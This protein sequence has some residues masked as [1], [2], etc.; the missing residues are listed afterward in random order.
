MRGGNKNKRI[1]RP[2]KRTLEESVQDGIPTLEEEKKTIGVDAKR[3]RQYNEDKVPSVNMHPSIACIE[4]K[5]ARLMDKA[6]Q[7]CTEKKAAREVVTI[8]DNVISAGV[9]VEDKVEIDGVKKPPVV[10]PKC[11]EK[12]EGYCQA[13]DP[14][15]HEACENYMD[16]EDNGGNREYLIRTNKVNPCLA[17]KIA[18]IWRR[19][20][21]HQ[22]VDGD[23]RDNDTFDDLPQGV[24]YGLKRMYLHQGIYAYGKANQIRKCR[25]RLRDAIRDCS[26]EPIIEYKPHVMDGF[27]LSPQYRYWYQGQ[28][29]DY[30]LYQDHNS[31]F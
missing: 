8:D 12:S 28:Y 9:H 2:V 14:N 18:T 17:K 24:A 4:G 7:D 5:K 19:Q 6:T 25:W 26:S 13:C 27:D 1:K 16:L 11:R 10:F 20:M 29:W 15:R 22:E 21:S 23:A 31:Y 3:I 30:Q